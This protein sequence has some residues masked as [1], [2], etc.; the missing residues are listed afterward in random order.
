LVVVI[1]KKTHTIIVTINTSEKEENFHTTFK[2]F[3]IESGIVVHREVVA[4]APPLRLSPRRKLAILL[5]CSDKYK[6]MTT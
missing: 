5:N 1:P 3:W 4:T 6:N 2:C